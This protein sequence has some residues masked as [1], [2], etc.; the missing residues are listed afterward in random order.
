MKLLSIFI[1]SFAFISFYSL[2]FA[3]LH[4]YSVVAQEVNIKLSPSSIEVAAKPNQTIGQTYRLANYGDPVT[5]RFEVLPFEAKD[6]SGQVV[7]KRRFEGPIRFSLD[8]QDNPSQPF[9]LK[10]NEIKEINL[11]IRIPEG[12]SEQDYYYSILAV[13][14]P[15][16]APEGAASV[17][18]K[19]T[20]GSQ[21]LIT[22]TSNGQVEIKPKIAL[23]KVAPRFS[24]NILGQ[25]I[26]LF[27]SFDKIPI[28]LLLDNKG[29]NL[30]TPRGTII[31][32][33][34][35]GRTKTFEIK[36][37]NVL[38]YSQKELLIESLPFSGFFLGNHKVSVSL[39]FGQGTP[40]LYA[41]TSFTVFPIK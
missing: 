27:D 41:L 29:K 5:V 9:L 6:P 24:I 16:P 28:K 33:G 21:L 23:F 15:P 12:L 38:A 25:Q 26:N 7:L 35:L 18:A 14:E 39:N 11:E 17:R 4:V 1:R 36:P 20:L 3:F 31:V 2:L 37:Q 22:V 10:T 34:L 32:K 30:I 13:T 8:S 40:S 19:I